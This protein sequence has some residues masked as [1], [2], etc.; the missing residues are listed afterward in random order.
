[1]APLIKE[2]GP[3]AGKSL[4]NVLIDSY[5]VGCQN[6][7]P[8]V[9]KRPTKALRLRPAAVPAT[10]MTG[11]FIESSDASERVLWDLRR[12]VADLF[13]DNYYTYFAE[14]CRKNGLLSSV[15][16]YDGPFECSQVARD[17]DIVMGEFWV[18]ADMRSSCKLAASVAHVFGK[19]FVGAESFTAAP[20]DAGWRSGPGSLKAVGDLM[21]SEGI[22]RCIIHRFA[23]QPWLNIEPGMTMGQ[24]GTHF[25]RT[26]T[27]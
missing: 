22:N 2:L 8:R 15:E 4:K 10:V 17:A 13:A 21:Y 24:W 20:Q 11:R 1:M 18:S 9:V 23:H 7:S 12:T 14:T 6:W 3:L 26:N 5:E 25:E 27:W 16:P 19:K